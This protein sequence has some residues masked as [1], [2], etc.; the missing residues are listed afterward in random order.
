MM[1]QERDFYSMMLNVSQ[2]SE[3]LRYKHQ[4][5]TNLGQPFFVLVY[6]GDQN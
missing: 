4:S 5:K 1:F 2:E 3:V 6:F